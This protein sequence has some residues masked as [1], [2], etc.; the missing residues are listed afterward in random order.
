VVF[1]TAEGYD[2]ET[3]LWCC[4]IKTPSLPD[5]PTKSDAENALHQLRIVFRTFPFADS[6]RQKENGL[7]VDV[8]NFDDPPGQDESVFLV[9]LLTAICRPRLRRDFPHPP[10]R[11]RLER[12]GR[13]PLRGH[14][15]NRDHLRFRDAHHA[16]G[17]RLRS[18]RIFRGVASINL[19]WLEQAAQLLQRRS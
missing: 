9:G 7:Q 12:F 19:E 8:V 11:S 16:G 14:E 18:A 5:H 2:R 6:T 1:A 3:K 10:G 17:R 13:Y 4:G 15:D